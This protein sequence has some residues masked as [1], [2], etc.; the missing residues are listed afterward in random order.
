MGKFHVGRNDKELIQTPEMA[1]NTIYI[2]RPVE[3]IREIQVIQIKEVPII[4]IHEVI[5]EIIVEKDV[6]RIIV[7]HKT[8]EIPV[9]YEKEVIKEVPV[10]IE[11]EVI[12]EVSTK[13]VDITGHIEV[14]RQIRQNKKLKIGL[15]VS[16][17]LNLILMVV[18]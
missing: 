10:Y 2:D 9:M 3:V 15:V 17:I 5:K 18:R 4:E 7:E 11:K 1:P 12:R 14:K 13:V 16:I 6:P 8:I